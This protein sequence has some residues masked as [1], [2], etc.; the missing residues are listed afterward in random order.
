M[1]SYQRY[2]VTEVILFNNVFQSTFSGMTRTCTTS[3]T[4]FWQETSPIL[5]M[6]SVYG[7]QQ[8]AKQAPTFFLPKCAEVSQSHVI[9]WSSEKLQ[10]LHVPGW[11][12]FRPRLGREEQ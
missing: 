4:F 6:A 2:D 7:V 1:H 3:N 10:A 12:L 11:P 8:T 5:Q 9:K